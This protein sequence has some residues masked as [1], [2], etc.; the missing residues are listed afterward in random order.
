MN[1]KGQFFL[2]AAVIISIIIISLGTI[3][4]A[5]KTVPGSGKQVY[6]LSREIEFESNKLIDH[7]VFNALTQEQ[8]TESLTNLMD[9]YAKTNPD[10]DLIM[11]YGDES[12]TITKALFYQE[13]SSGSFSIGQAKT[14]ITTIEP[15][16]IS[17]DIT[18][19]L[20]ENKILVNLNADTQ[21][22]FDLEP[23]E[24]FFIVLAKQIGDEKIVSAE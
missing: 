14:T 22:E 8:K 21:I 11:I 6:D 18:L 23:G 10:T 17:N 15:I 9:Y 16:D 4:I 3:Y 12:G 13:R 19:K 20:D 1:K 2:I 7:G 5:T 24:N